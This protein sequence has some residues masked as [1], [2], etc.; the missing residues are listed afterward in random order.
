MQNIAT[1][2]G[3]RFDELSVLKAFEVYPWWKRN[4]WLDI[5]FTLP[6]YARQGAIIPM[7]SPGVQ[8]LSD[9]PELSH[10]DPAPYEGSLQVRVFTGG[11]GRFD[12]YDGAS[13]GYMD[14]TIADVDPEVSA[15]ILEFSF[16]PGQV[17]EHANV[18]FYAAAAEAQLDAKVFTLTPTD[19]EAVVLDEVG[20]DMHAWKG[21]L[22]GCVAR[23]E[24]PTRWLVH[25]PSSVKGY[26]LRISEE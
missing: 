8:T 3:A 6:L 16:T 2:R 25:V 26:S 5:S 9:K 21:C 14:P 17:F 10:L 13:F 12:T 24:A 11:E 19:G 22:G 7:L 20:A 1:S 18:E 15:Q 4:L 23:F